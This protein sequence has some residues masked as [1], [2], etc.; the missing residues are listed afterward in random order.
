M[1]INEIS[2]LFTKGISDDEIKSVTFDVI[3]GSTIKLSV[4]IRRLH[5]AIE[6]Q[7][8]SPKVLCESWLYLE[9]MKND[10]SM[11]GEDISHSEKELSDILQA[12]INYGYQKILSSI[13]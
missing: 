7:A 1:K 12:L 13:T 9:M 11:I 10:M 6:Y 5:N 3:H 4:Y 8:H 2:P